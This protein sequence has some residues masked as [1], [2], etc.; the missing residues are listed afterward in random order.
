V[1][2]DG[3]G[4]SQ[5]SVFSGSYPPFFSNILHNKEHRRGC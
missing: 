2:G 3:S 1:I 4:S 5:F